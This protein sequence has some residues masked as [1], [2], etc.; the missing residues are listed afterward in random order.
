VVD[1]TLRA[2]NEFHVVGLATN[3]NQLRSILANSDVRDGQARTTLLSE[4]EQDHSL[5][6]AKSDALL[7]L[8]QQAK[9]INGA[10]RSVTARISQDTGLAVPQ[11][12]RGAESKI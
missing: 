10:G 11:G 12:E 3:L 2:L 7:L 5:N 1:R 9:T 6:S 4:I 8:D